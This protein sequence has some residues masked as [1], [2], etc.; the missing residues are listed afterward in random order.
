[1]PIYNLV[2]SDHLFTNVGLRLLWG[3]RSPKHSSEEDMDF[4]SFATAE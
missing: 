4:N 1:M 3:I 2:P